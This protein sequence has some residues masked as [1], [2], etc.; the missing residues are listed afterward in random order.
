MK[1]HSRLARESPGPEVGVRGTRPTILDL[2][3]HVAEGSLHFEWAYGAT[4]HRR[5]T[6]E[7]L[8]RRFL[9]V[10]QELTAA[11]RGETERAS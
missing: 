4:L 10:I 2:T 5:A 8:A 11:S 9:A 1:S 3:A 6:I 7:G